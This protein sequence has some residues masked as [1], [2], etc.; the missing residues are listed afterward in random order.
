MP[1]K[2]K[3]RGNGG[4]RD[5]RGDRASAPGPS[6]GSGPHSLPPRPPPP[7]SRDDY[8][9]SSNRDD[10]YSRDRDN[11]SRY[12]DSR[13]DYGRRFPPPPVPL[14]SSRDV[15]RPPQGE[16]TF[17]AEKPSGVRES[18]A[19]SWRPQDDRSYGGRHDHD[20]P[21]HFS[22][23]YSNRGQRGGR[24][25]RGG[26]RGGTRPPRRVFVPAERELL[27][28]PHSTGPELALYKEGGVTFRPLDELS[29]SEEAEMD[30]S[31]DEAQGASE[32]SHKRTRLA[33]D[34]SAADGDSVPKWS[35]PDPYTAIPPGEAAAP[36]KG[37]DVV[38][39]IRK[40]RVVATTEAK[41]SIPTEAVDFIACD[42]SD[43]SEN[44]TTFAHT[45]SAPQSRPPGM[46]GAPSGPRALA[47]ANPDTGRNDAPPSVLQGSASQIKTVQVLS[48]PGY[49][50]L[51]PQ[52]RAGDP[53]G[54][55]KRTH[56]DFIKM[57][58]TRL[59]KPGG[60]PASFVDKKAYPI[61]VPPFTIY[62]DPGEDE[63]PWMVADHSDCR[64]PAV[65]LHKEI[66]DFYEYLR[67]RDFEE[68]IRGEV[69]DD[70]KRFCRGLWR[71]AE[72]YSFGSFPTGLYL[73]TSDM[74]VVVVSDQVLHGTGPP[75]YT[76]KRHLYIFGGALRKSKRI[77]FNEIENIVG[78]RV[79]LVKYVDHR[80]RLKVDVSFENPGGL[81][82]V[83]T[84]N[85]WK[86][87]YPAMPILVTLIKHLLC[88]HGLNEPVNGGIGG[89]TVICLVVSMLQLMPEVQSRSMD[90]M[91]HLGELFMN[92]LDLYG[93]KFNYQEVAISLN[94][95]RYI[96]K[97]M[98]TTV[99][100]KQHD[101]LSIIDPNN[102]ENDVSGGSKLFKRVAA[103]FQD[104]HSTLQRQLVH[105]MDDPPRGRS[106]L[107]PLFAADYS[108]FR[109]QRA[110]LDRLANPRPSRGGHRQ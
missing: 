48:G 81:Q 44:G 31:G 18:H 33:R 95:P 8:R 54:S 63:R 102:P 67:P 76:E 90:P 68:R 42:S 23:G 99:V 50:P 15:Y 28:A 19:D 64:L 4:P 66:V 57:P 45:D 43:E 53:L 86:E 106:L 1:S 87:Q 52:D 62:E 16:F 17:R 110:H 26:G 61:W 40:A 72:V 46:P 103:I 24:N 5:H 80:T 75:K 89:F 13:Y 82:A 22:G 84:F 34:P 25:A 77:L 60:A 69:I 101:R 58:E 85:A 32:P 98:V 35:N 29:D 71:D 38:H 108:S 51:K 20:A 104:A 56:D 109:Q 96:P 105:A 6:G 79:P 97:N 78:A 47:V 92:F 49:I 74:D 27:N 73:P 88:L 11:S 94:P 39:L 93:N 83:K 14:Q 100:Y 2:R 3:D 36:N 7:A 107:S 12:D 30:I 37:R 9:P 10:H 70:L 91:H 55:R 65:W 21:R 41:S 59:S